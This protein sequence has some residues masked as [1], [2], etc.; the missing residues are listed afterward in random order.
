MTFRYS[1][2]ELPGSP[3]VKFEAG[4]S[5]LCAERSGQ[6]WVLHTFPCLLTMEDL[7]AR[8]ISNNRPCTQQ[9]PYWPTCGKPSFFLSSHSFLSLDCFEGNLWHCFIFLVSI[10][11]HTVKDKDFLKPKHYM[12]LSHGQTTKGCC[13]SEQKSIRGQS[14]QRRSS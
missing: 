6:L 4:G 14:T 12:V 1:C 11:V 2:L 9:F 3:T 8:R 13:K 10:S 5:L 7:E